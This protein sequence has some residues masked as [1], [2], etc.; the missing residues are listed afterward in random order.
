MDQSNTRNHSHQIYQ[1]YAGIYDQSGQRSFSLRMVSYLESLF[2]RHGIGGRSLLDVACGT[3][4]LACAMAAKG[5]E[6]IGVDASAA[7]LAQARAKA[8]ERGLAVRWEQ[9]DMRTL[10]LDRRVAVTT[11]FYDS[12]NYMLTS[13]DLVKA[14]RAAH[15]SLEPGGWYLFDMNTA[16]CF[17]S[18]WDGDAYVHESSDLTVL[19]SGAYDEWRQRVHATVTWFERQ[20]ELWAKGSE[21]HIE[22]AYPPEQIATHLQD[23]GFSIEGWYDCF[24]FR[25]P[26]DESVRIVWAARRR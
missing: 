5:W 11:C 14:F 2:Q 10:Q 25:E 13:D 3:G 4:T 26:D 18:Q 9:Q 15:Q 1:R 21:D 7:M 20:G 16:Y 6:V 23:V 8:D 22:Q 24:T 19:I 17:A 12:L